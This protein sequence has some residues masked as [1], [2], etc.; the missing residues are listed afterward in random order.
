M[1]VQRNVI[2]SA[3]VFV[4]LY[5]VCVDISEVLIKCRWFG[6]PLE[7]CKYNSWQV[8]RLYFTAVQNRTA[9][10]EKNLLQFPRYINSSVLF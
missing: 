8:V 5:I 6:V 7:V 2:F 10:A 4:V 1:R 3:L 9:Y